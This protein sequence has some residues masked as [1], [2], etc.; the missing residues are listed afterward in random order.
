[1][2]FWPLFSSKLPASLLC[3][4]PSSM[5]LS[6]LSCL[7]VL[8]SAVYLYPPHKG[9]TLLFYSLVSKQAYMTPFVRA[10][11]F[12]KNNL[13]ERKR[14]SPWSGR[15]EEG[16]VAPQRCTGAEAQYEYCFRSYSGAKQMLSEIITFTMKCSLHH[17]LQ[18]MMK[19]D[20]DAAFSTWFCER[21]KGRIVGLISF[22]TH[23]AESD[24][25][26]TQTVMNWMNTWTDK[27]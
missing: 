3:P 1:M 24:T 16:Q 6:L 10:S 22:W 12:W 25:S 18:G 14:L 7:C 26:W 9:L 8:C 21:L 15:N 23:N 11:A 17:N 19:P 13:K 2:K 4:H 27:E 5:A 20:V